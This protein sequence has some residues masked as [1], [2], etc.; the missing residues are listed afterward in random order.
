[1]H[2]IGHQYMGMDAAGVRGRGFLQ[3]TQIAA[4]VFLGDETRL[5][6]IAALHDVLRSA[7]EMEAGQASHTKLAT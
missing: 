3:S 5:A 6:I 4:I 7:G 2:V 1:M